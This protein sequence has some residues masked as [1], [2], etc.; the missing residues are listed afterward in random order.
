MGV[1]LF[2]HTPAN[3]CQLGDG[4][5]VDPQYPGLFERPFISNSS[6]FSTE[7][8]TNY[9]STS[10]DQLVKL[11]RSSSQG[12][13]PS[14]RILSGSGGRFTEVT[15]TTG[16]PP[17]PITGSPFTEDTRINYAYYANPL[18]ARWTGE[19]PWDLQTFTSTADFTRSG[20]G[21]LLPPLGSVF[22]YSVPGI[23]DTA[24]NA[25]SY[26]T[27]PLPNEV[28]AGGVSEYSQTAQWNVFGQ[29][30]EVCCWNEG[31]QIE[32]NLVINK[33]DFTAVSDTT[34]GS[35]GYHIY[36]LGSSSYHTTLTQTVTIDSTWT[37]TFS[38]LL[39]QFQ[40]PKVLGHF[41]YVNDF[42]ISSVTA[43]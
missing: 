17:T 5:L 41:T 16:F 38:T 31:Y 4:T 8:F 18:F 19:T 34:P 21:T 3:I 6:A 22:F 1:I 25:V 35:Y 12:S 39:H 14:C 13:T 36:T 23:V 30:D 2:R 28:S 7:A 29:A 32:L 42:Y 9:P 43:P 20:L 26:E 40:I 27:G 37:T 11:I 33:V 24:K 15:V 10:P